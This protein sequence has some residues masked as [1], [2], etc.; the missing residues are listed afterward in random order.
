MTAVKN[1]REQTEAFATLSSTNENHAVH[2]CLQ[3][4]CKLA[5]LVEN[6]AVPFKLYVIIKTGRARKET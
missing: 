6:S 2:F 1:K 4:E 3:H 5:N